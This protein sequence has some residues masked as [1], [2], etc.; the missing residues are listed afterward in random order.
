MKILIVKFGIQKGTTERLFYDHCKILASIN[1]DISTLSYKDDDIEAH[2]PGSIENFYIKNYGKWD[3]V[4]GWKIKNMVQSIKPDII[5]AHGSRAAD[6]MNKFCS[7]TPVLTVCHNSQMKNLDY[8]EN[9]LVTG[10]DVK[11]SLIVQGVDP[12]HIYQALE[13]IFL[14]DYQCKKYGDDFYSN[15]LITV[16]TITRLKLRN[17]H[18][19]LLQAISIL[20]NRGVKINAIISSTGAEESVL[21]KLA[22][23]LMVEDIVKFTG[24]VEDKNSFFSAID[25]L[26]VPALTGCLAHSIIEGFAAQLPVISSNLPCYKD[27]A[28]ST[29]NS[30]LVQVGEADDLASAIEQ[31]YHDRKLA[32]KIAQAGYLYA[33]QHYQP[34]DL[35]NELYKILDSIAGNKIFI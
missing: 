8:A 27:I 11:E 9:I 7:F 24:W 3:P 34:H 21:K 23:D 6:L 29:V 15:D 14:P 1:C 4:A 18:K 22:H 33:K 35:G 5:I 31:L 10:S 30:L 20:R 26:C 32:F 12:E 28:H 19:T 17:G 25:I 13:P 2:I 16:G